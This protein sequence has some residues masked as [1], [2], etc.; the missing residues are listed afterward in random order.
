VLTRA[1]FATIIAYISFS[2]R[3]TIAN[4]E[5][6]KVKHMSS[7]L[8]SNIVAESVISTPLTTEHLNLTQYQA[9]FIH[10]LSSKFMTLKIL[11]NVIFLC[12]SG[13]SRKHRQGS[14]VTEIL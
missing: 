11:V 3:I 7:R 6:Q 8:I 4:I 14:L 5:V 9:Y 10:L 13:F 2:E 1:L 12:S